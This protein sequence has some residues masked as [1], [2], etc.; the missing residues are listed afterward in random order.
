MKYSDVH[1]AVFL[2]RPNRFIA[3]CLVDREE[4]AVHAE[5]TGPIGGEEVIAHLKNTARCCIGGEE[6][7]A[8]VKNTARCCIGGEEVIAHVKNTAR[9]CIGG[10][11]VVT[12]VKNTARCSIGGEE[13]VA[14]VKNTGRCRELLL[15]GATVWLQHHDNP[16]RKTRWSLIAVQKGERLINMDSQ[17]PNQIAAEAIMDGTLVFPGWEHP[18][19]VRREV[20][21][22][23]SRFDLCLTK[24]GRQAFVEVKGVTLEQDGAVYFPDAPTERGVK[25][26]RELCKA[27]EQGFGAFILFV[28]QMENVRFFAPNDKTHPAFGQALREAEKKGVQIVAADCLVAPDEVRLHSRV[29]VKL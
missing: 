23:D 1:R 27:L 16:A 28:I 24:G 6:V 25:H 9:C 11:E 29:P 26:V 22:G 7:T 2:S 5:N 4:A 19:E 10:E 8:H 21:Y 13:V 3:H 20:R 17:A 14:H 18:D 15:P 12:H